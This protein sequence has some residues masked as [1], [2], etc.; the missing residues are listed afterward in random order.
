MNLRTFNEMPAD[1]QEILLAAARVYNLDITAMTIPTDVRGRKVLADG[2]METVMM[3][4]EELREA[5]EWCW[6]EFTSKRG[7]MPHID[8]MIDI[9]TDAREMYKGYYGPKQLPV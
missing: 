5:A 6:N 8:K 4:E 7:S 9:Y 3:P 1:L 2:G